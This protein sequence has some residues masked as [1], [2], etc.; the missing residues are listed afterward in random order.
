MNTK[1]ALIL[2]Y[3]SFMLPLVIWIMSAFFQTVPWDI[4]EAALIDGCTPLSALVRVIL[5]LAAP[6]LAV[7]A[8]VAFLYA[9][10]VFLALILPPPCSLRRS[11]R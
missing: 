7:A 6:G 4:E 3:T 5:P 1:A 9:W 8:I 2:T 11:R 10:N